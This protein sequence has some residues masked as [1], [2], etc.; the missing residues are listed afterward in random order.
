MVIPL[1]LLILCFRHRFVMGLWPLRCRKYR[2]LQWLNSTG[3]FLRREILRDGFTSFK[4]DPWRNSLVVQWLG[5]YV[6]AV[7]GMGLIPGWEIK[8]LKAESKPP[9]QKKKPNNNN[10]TR[11]KGPQGVLFSPFASGH[12]WGRLWHLDQVERFGTSP[13]A[14]A[15]AEDCRV[16]TYRA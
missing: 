12:C 1:L 9:P 16:K 5:C 14:K 13:R 10:K 11:A 7:E 3:G 4:K 15:K 8:I 6:Y 2:F